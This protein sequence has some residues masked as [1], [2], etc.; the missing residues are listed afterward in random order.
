MNI[1]GVQPPPRAG[2]EGFR[3]VNLNLF[4]SRAKRN[5]AGV[6]ILPLASVDESDLRAWPT[7]HPTEELRNSHGGLSALASMASSSPRGAVTHDHRGNIAAMGVG[8]HNR[9]NRG[10]V[11]LDVLLSQALQQPAASPQADM[12]PVVVS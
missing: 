2:E 5:N 1:G 12:T 6:M 3:P 11:P 9:S 4:K 7:A 10:I 8:P